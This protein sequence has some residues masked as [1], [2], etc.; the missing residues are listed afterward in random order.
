LSEEKKPPKGEPTGGARYR[1]Y[2][3]P[4]Y[5]PKQIDEV[6]TQ[7]MKDWQSKKAM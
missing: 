1:Q 4:E 6:I 2:F 7:L 3:P 5:S